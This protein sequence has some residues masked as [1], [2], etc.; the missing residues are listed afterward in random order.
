MKSRSRS[1]NNPSPANGGNTCPGAG[2]DRE[3]CTGGQCT[4]RDGN[5]GLWSSWSSCGSN[6]VKSRSRSCNNPS[7]V[8]GGNSCPG[9]DQENRTCTGGF[10]SPI[11]TVTELK[12][13]DRLIR[14]AND[15]NQYPNCC[16]VS[17]IFKRYRLE[18]IVLN[19]D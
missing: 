11:D 16:L 8:N 9:S 1:C 4:P 18:C 7:P 13:C 3:S 15:L 14:N 2:Q 10:C 6:C 17:E 12:Q 19:I 5:W